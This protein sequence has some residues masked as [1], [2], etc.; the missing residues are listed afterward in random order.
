M[1]PSDIDF[2]LM[3]SFYLVASV[4]IAVLLGFA[5]KFGLDD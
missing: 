5:F 1:E 2:L 4:P 3:L